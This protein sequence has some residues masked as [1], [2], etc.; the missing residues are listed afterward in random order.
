MDLSGPRCASWDG[1]LRESRSRAD[2]CRA[3]TSV[4]CTAADDCREFHDDPERRVGAAGRPTISSGGVVD[5]VDVRPPAGR[6]SSQGHGGP[7]AWASRRT[8]Q[9]TRPCSPPTRIISEST[10]SRHWGDAL[11]WSSASATTPSPWRPPT[12]HDASPLTPRPRIAGAGPGPAARAEASDTRS[13]GR[14]EDGDGRLARQGAGDRSAAPRRGAD[15]QA[16]A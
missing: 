5:G 8:C 3:D 2:S 9:T 7:R 4:L 15:G 11:T 16:A 14:S 10:E 13:A 6:I 1:G 12:Q